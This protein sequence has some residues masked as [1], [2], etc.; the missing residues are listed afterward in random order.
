MQDWVGRHS[1]RLAQLRLAV[2][3]KLGLVCFVDHANLGVDRECPA[4]D[5]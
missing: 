3:F 1:R 2:S 5:R 4:V